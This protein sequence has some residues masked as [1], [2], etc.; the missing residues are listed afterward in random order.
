MQGLEAPVCA[1]AAEIRMTRAPW[2]LEIQQL[3]S[4]VPCA[5]RNSCAGLPLTLGFAR[6]QGVDLPDFLSFQAAPKSISHPPNT[7]SLVPS[8][9]LQEN[10]QGVSDEHRFP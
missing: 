7:D 4:W 5:E 8:K 10:Q 6:E 2:T 3:C 1:G 9:A